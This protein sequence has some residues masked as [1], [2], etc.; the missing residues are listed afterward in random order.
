[1]IAEKAADLIRGRRPLDPVIYKTW[2]RH[3]LAQLLVC[4]SV[5][6]EI[7]RQHHAAT[8]LPQRAGV[9]YR[10]KTE[11]V[12]GDR[13]A[14]ATRN[15]TPAGWSGAIECPITVLPMTRRANAS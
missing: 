15:V 7:T 5:D 13:A 11:T 12:R 6:H 2:R 9:L 4:R 3:G 14:I 1:M 8:S 10:K